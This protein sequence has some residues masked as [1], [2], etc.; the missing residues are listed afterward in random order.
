MR[1]GERQRVNVEGCVRICM[2]V[3]CIIICVRVLYTM[4]RDQMSKEWL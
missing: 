2:C 4:S 3:G 1:E